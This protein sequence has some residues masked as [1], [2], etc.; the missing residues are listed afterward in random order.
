MEAIGPNAYIWGGLTSQNRSGTSSYYGYDSQGSVRI[1]TNS[2]GA[3][4]D[5]YV[6]TAFGVELL[7][8][9]G[10]NNPFRYV[11]L[12]GYYMTFINLYY[13]R[14]RWLDTVKGRWDSRAG[15][16]EQKA[17]EHPYG[18]VSNSVDIVIDPSGM[19]G[20]ILFPVSSGNLACFAPTYISLRN[21]GMSNACEIALKMCK[22]NRND[23][24]CDDIHLIPRDRL[25]PQPSVVVPGP[26]NTPRVK[27]VTPITPVGP[28]S[29]S[30]ND[31]HSQTNNGG[32][33]RAPLLIT[34]I[35]AL[36]CIVFPELC[37]FTYIAPPVPGV[38]PNLEPPDYPCTSAVKVG[39]N[40][41]VN[42]ACK[43]SH[44]KM[45]CTQNTKD[46]D[47]PIMIARLLNCIALG[48]LRENWC[49]QG[50]DPGHVTQIEDRERSLWICIAM[51]ERRLRRKAFRPK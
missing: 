43:D 37:A 23:V 39:M 11:G 3:V 47:I 5:S 2:A 9:S 50:G 35:A 18:Y 8:G 44:V 13:V 38:G 30:P 26:A 40:M 15:I 1:L 27:P 33:S 6:Y 19:Q 20:F 25:G 22:L 12:Y 49:Y 17:G 28:I 42:E 34:E 16:G 45:R 41:L 36:F 46:A 14:A 24:N 10:T 29:H 51:Y 4:T 32:G 48:Q 7:N 21:Q 31:C